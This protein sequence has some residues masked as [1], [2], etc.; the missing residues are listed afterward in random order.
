MAVLTLSNTILSL[1]INTRILRKGVLISEKQTESTRQVLTSRVAP[2][3]KNERI[4]LGANHN[5]KILI[6]SEHLSV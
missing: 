2:K 6:G 3:N 1:S 4:K 5:N